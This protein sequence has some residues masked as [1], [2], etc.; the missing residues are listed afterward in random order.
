MEN[1]FL[2]NRPG[3]LTMKWRIKQMDKKGL[4]SAIFIFIFM[5]LLAA[6][7]VRA[8]GSPE[9]LSEAIAALQSEISA[10]GANWQ[11][12]MTSMLLLSPEERR[13]RLGG[14]SLENTPQAAVLPPL[15]DTT[16]SLPSKLDWRN[17]QGLDWTTPVKNQ[18]NCGSCWAFAVIAGIE[19]R[20]K[21]RNGNAAFNPDLSEQDLVSCSNA[22]T[23]GG[24]WD[25]LA[26]QWMKDHGVPNETCFPYAAI[27]APCNSTCSDVVKIDDW[28]WAGGTWAST[29]VNAIKQALLDGP[30][31]TY[32]TVYTDFFFYSNGIYKMVLGALEGGHLVSIIGWDDTTTPPCWIVKNSWG[33][34]WGENGYFRIVMGKNECNIEKQTSYAI[35]HDNPTAEVCDGIDNDC[36]GV[37]DNGFDVG[38]ACTAGIGACMA[39]G[40]KICSSDGSTTVCN[41]TPGTA[42]AEIC[43]GIDNDCDGSV[44]E[45]LLPSPI[46]PSSPANGASDVSLTPTL[47][48]NALPRAISY[49]LTLADD[50]GKVII[51]QAHLTTTYFN[52][53]SGFLAENTTYTWKVIATNNCGQSGET[54]PFSFKTISPD[55]PS[56]TLVTP[57]GGEVLTHGTS[58][59]ITWDYEG[60][61]GTY[62]K[63][64]YNTGGRTWIAITATAICVD[65]RFVWT[66]QGVSSTRCRVRITSLDDRNITDLSDTNFEIR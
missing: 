43:D 12:G 54:T 38:Q 6:S 49:H 59:E 58:Y 57:N 40:T 21:I 37:I 30:V 34:G 26:M 51:D 35:F 36:D 63:I 2:F 17:Y 32:L 39:S 50:S 48:W 20:M 45:D 66:V 8:Q 64:E 52:V 11:A 9:D 5:L 13:A 60:N 29:D 1:I 18:G 46:I 27:D 31:S 4:M 41:A 19:S 10:A 44:D 23:C 56:L 22:G 24:G 16:A 61:P 33:T 65:R 14:I 53:L 28:A 62:V 7:P 25:Y 47:T 3:T 42:S 15:S 55:S